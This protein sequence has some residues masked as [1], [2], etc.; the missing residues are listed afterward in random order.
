MC[1]GV[2]A[3]AVI[4]L[5]L[6]R[7]VSGPRVLRG[8]GINKVLGRGCNTTGSGYGFQNLRCWES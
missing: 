4:R 1:W 6:E 8:F 3:H 7:R 2:D 5:K